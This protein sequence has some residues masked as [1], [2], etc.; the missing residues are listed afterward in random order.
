MTPCRT[1]TE[2]SAYIVPLV[3]SSASQKAGK[4]QERHRLGVMGSSSIPVVELKVPGLWHMPWTHTEGTTQSSLSCR[5][6]GGSNNCRHL[7]CARHSRHCA[8]DN[9]APTLEGRALGQQMAEPL[10]SGL[11]LREVPYEA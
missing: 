5:M 1:E 2:T 11:S 9:I 7:L 4:T 8:I 3:I 6:S 10:E